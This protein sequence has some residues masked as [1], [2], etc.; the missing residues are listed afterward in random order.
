MSD[1]YFKTQEREIH[2]PNDDPNRASMVKKGLE[3]W[4]RGDMKFENPLEEREYLQSVASNPHNVLG[5][6]AWY[7]PE[8]IVSFGKFTEKHDCTKW[9]HRWSNNTEKFCIECFIDKPNDENNINN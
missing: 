6:P 3:R 2:H 9:G 4:K 8:K 7:P 1:F 5:Y